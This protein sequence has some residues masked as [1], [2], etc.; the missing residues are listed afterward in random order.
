MVPETGSFF[1]AGSSWYWIRREEGDEAEKGSKEIGH[2]IFP[3]TATLAEP[4]NWLQ[5]RQQYLLFMSV[6]FWF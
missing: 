4:F 6:Y 3:S 2:L 1:L 5:T